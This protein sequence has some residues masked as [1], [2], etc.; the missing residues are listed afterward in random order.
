MA[1]HAGGVKIQSAA[2]VYILM[3]A[4]FGTSGA[5]AQSAGSFSCVYPAYNRPCQKADA[6]RIEN[7]LALCFN[8]ADIS[9]IYE[10]TDLAAAAERYAGLNDPSRPTG[11][12]CC[13]RSWSWNRG[14]RRNPVGTF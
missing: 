5:E 9:G 1:A 13:S 10:N 7:E 3:T 6:L 14:E 8:R 2:A 12:H 11:W 4:S